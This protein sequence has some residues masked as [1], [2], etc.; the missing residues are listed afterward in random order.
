MPL[1]CRLLPD[2]RNMTYGVRTASLSLTGWICTGERRQHRWT[3]FPLSGHCLICHWLKYRLVID[4]ASVLSWEQELESLLIEIPDGA[5]QRCP[6][7]TTSSFHK[8][9]LKFCLWVVLW[10]P[11]VPS[12]EVTWVSV[13][14]RQVLRTFEGCP[15]KHS[16]ANCSCVC[17]LI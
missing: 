2:C 14:H 16:G 4:P 13:L 9:L 5:L 11:I 7:G 17:Y 6:A 10:N 8:R 3:N 15:T 12:L 1:D